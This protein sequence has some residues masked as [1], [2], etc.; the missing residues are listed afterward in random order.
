MSPTHGEG[1]HHDGMTARQTLLYVFI[2]A[3]WRWREVGIV[4]KT[5]TKD[6]KAAV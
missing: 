1:K 3:S 6:E 4:V 5:R 2:A